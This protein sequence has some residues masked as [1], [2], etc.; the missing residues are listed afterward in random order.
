[1]LGVSGVWRLDHVA[2]VIGEKKHPCTPS[3]VFP[4]LIRSIKAAAEVVE[5][6][7]T[8]VKPEEGLNN[9]AR[10]RRGKGQKRRDDNVELQVCRRERDFLA[11]VACSRLGHWPARWFKSNHEADQYGVTLEYWEKQTADEILNLKWT[12]VTG[13]GHAAF[14]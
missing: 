6:L 7:L 3:S 12:S 13:E 8:P 10:W 5:T 14:R 4:I 11:S 1:M 9:V 2:Q